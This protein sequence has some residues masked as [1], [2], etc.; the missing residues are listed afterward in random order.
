MTLKRLTV[1]IDDE[2]HAKAKGKAYS[3]GKTLKEKVIELLK[4]WLKE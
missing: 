2:L 3:E 1:E 4:A